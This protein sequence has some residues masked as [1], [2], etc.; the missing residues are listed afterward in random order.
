M[1]HPCRLGTTPKPA[2][3]FFEALA[4][5]P[6][7]WYDVPGLT[8]ISYTENG[9]KVL[10]FCTIRYT[11]LWSD[12]MTRGRCSGAGSGGGSTKRGVSLHQAAATE[13]AS[14]DLLGEHVWV[15]LQ[16][17]IYSLIEL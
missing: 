7:Q 10:V 9:E 3:L 1:Q 16:N 12:E 6:G 11:A 8:Q 2:C 17:N 4:V 15:R 14:M 5:Q 13:N